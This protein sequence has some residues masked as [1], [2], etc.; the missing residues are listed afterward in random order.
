VKAESLKGYP[1]GVGEMHPPV[2]QVLSAELLESRMKRAEGLLRAR[3]QKLEVQVAHQDE[4]M[5]Q[6]LARL[7]EQIGDHEARL[8]VNTEGVTQFKLFAGLA[9]GGSGIMSLVALIKAFLGS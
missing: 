2:D 9:S 1:D 5:L 7:E 8:R 6:R 4:L 3:I